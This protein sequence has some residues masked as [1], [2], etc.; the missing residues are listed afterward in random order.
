M[1]D[2]AP[3]PQPRT[4][5]TGY[6]N[7]IAKDRHIAIL[8]AENAALREQLVSTQRELIDRNNELLEARARRRS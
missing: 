2:H 4:C 5:S 6:C 8:E 7:C 3:Q 1:T